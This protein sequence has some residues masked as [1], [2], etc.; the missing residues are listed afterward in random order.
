MKKLCKLI[1]HSLTGISIVIYLLNVMINSFGLTNT[2]ENAFEFLNILLLS[3][4]S[5]FMFS[6]YYFSFLDKLK[7]NMFG[8]CA[9]AMSLFLHLIILD[10]IPDNNLPLSLVLLIFEFLMTFKFVDYY[11]QDFESKYEKSKEVLQETIL[12]K[13]EVVL[14]SKI[15]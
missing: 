14:K 13:K 15:I 4:L 11:N 5:T 1:F 12:L 9:V 6:V 3:G 8:L 7:S 2:I 10:L